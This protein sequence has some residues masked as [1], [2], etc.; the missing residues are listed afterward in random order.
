MLTTA[1]LSLRLARMRE[2]SYDTD[3]GEVIL[4][5]NVTAG[6][7]SSLEMEEGLGVFFH[8]RYE[9]AHKTRDVLSAVSRR[10]NDMICCAIMEHRLLGY[11]TVVEPAEG[12]RWADIGRSLMD[13]AGT[14]K[15]PVLFELGSIEISAP[16]RSKGLARELMRFTFDDPLFEQRVVFSRELSWHW[17]LKS[18]DQ[19]VYAYRSMLHRLFESAGFRLCET[20]DEEIGYAGENMFMTRVGDKVPAEVA[21]AFYR[22]LCKSEPRGWGWG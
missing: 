19:S 8:Y 11:L 12:T 14:G 21:F 3:G 13:L 16:W 17:D 18:S 22:S 7:L 6:L 15:A 10:C 20:D 9:D 5:G 1:P 4:T 2:R